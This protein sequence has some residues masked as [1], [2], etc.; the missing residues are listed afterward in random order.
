MNKTQTHTYTSKD[1]KSRHMCLSSGATLPLPMP[2]SMMP[3]MLISTTLNSPLCYHVSCSLMLSLAI[4]FGS[5]T[6]RV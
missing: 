5:I 1:R 3:S 4:W 6:S 2:T